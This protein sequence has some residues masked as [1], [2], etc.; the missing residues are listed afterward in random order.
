MNSRTENIAAMKNL[1]NAKCSVGSRTGTGTLNCKE[2]V[3]Q[4]EHKGDEG[5]L[6]LKRQINARSEVKGEEQIQFLEK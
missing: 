3:L 5:R 4:T 2:S 6:N 1:G